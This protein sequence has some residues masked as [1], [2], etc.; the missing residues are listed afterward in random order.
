[1][2]TSTF[3][4]CTNLT[5]LPKNLFGFS[6]ECKES[7]FDATFI[8]CSKLKY[9][10][11]NLFSGLYGTPK[12]DAFKH[13]F[14]AA[15][16][17]TINYYNANGDVYNTT[18]FLPA[19]FFGNLNLSSSNYLASAFA[20][21]FGNGSPLTT[22]TEGCPSGTTRA[23]YDSRYIS[24]MSSKVLCEYN[25][26]YENM[27]GA[28]NF[29]N[30]PTNYIDNAA[31]I[32]LGTP[33]KLGNT[34]GGWFDNSSFTGNAV[35]SI[36]AYSYGA[37]PLYA[38]WTPITYECLAGQYLPKGSGW[39]NNYEDYGCTQ[40][41]TDS[42]CPPSSGSYTI[43]DNLDQ[44]LNSCP[45]DN[46]YAPAGMWNANQCGRKLHVGDE[47]L[48]L[49]QSPA[50][51]TDH[52]FKISYNNNTYSANTVQRD[53]NS[54]TFPKMSAG[55]T[56]GLHITIGGVEYLVCDDSTCPNTQSAGSGSDSGSY[57]GGNNPIVIT[58]QDG[59]EHTCVGVGD[60]D[61]ISTSCYTSDGYRCFRGLDNSWNCMTIGG[62]N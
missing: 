27:S 51:P 25:I 58:D 38:K 26:T 6:A 30:A 42:Y 22:Q 1:M 35:Q 16:F 52:T 20:N 36:P 48:Y 17:D 54:N 62:S 37:Q 47:V 15:N 56:K 41:P 55:A 24:N 18:S 44:G 13:T 5:T 39:T 33:S 34:F 43:Q 50:N 7:M 45:V 61:D 3:H 31:A 4:S 21:T 40:C 9:V 53:T 19:N 59:D 28:I 14:Y 32:P 8:Y 60:T 12:A 11:S 46:P 29:T 10:P 23:K 2:F 57:S 49:H